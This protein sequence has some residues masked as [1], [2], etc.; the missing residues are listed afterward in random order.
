MILITDTLAIPE[1]EIHFE[2]SRSGGPGG[3]HVNTT[4]TRVTLRFDVAGSAGL[5]EDQKR[6]IAA[7]LGTRMSKEGV[8]RVV[9]Q[10]SRSQWENRET[11]LARFV[12]LLRG[13]LARAKARRAT[14]PTALARERRLQ[15]KRLQSRTK[16]LRR[17]PE[18]ED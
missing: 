8:L 3:Q 11:A 1:E 16:R 6:R 17:G 5:D 15:D 13:A 14:Q 7:R 10:A 9:A 12:L 2:F 4:S 18:S